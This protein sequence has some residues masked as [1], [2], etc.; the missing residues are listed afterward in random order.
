MEEKWQQKKKD[1]LIGALTLV[2]QCRSIYKAKCTLDGK[3]LD[4]FRE[5]MR[6]LSMIGI[7]PVTIPREWNIEFISNLLKTYYDMLAVKHEKEF[8]EQNKREIL[9]DYFKDCRK[10][11]KSPWK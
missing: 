7:N 3:V 5:S 1:R 9:E 6:D 4:R 2:S 10:L 8:L 11:G